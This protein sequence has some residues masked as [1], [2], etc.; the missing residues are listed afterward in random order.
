MPAA[1]APAW[2]SIQSGPDATTAPF[3]G[4]VSCP[5]NCTESPSGSIPESGMVILT[6]SPAR[7]RAVTVLGTGGLF[8]AASRS[9]TAMDTSAVAH[10]PSA[11]T[12]R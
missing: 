10:C 11:P 1:Y 6:V 5:M 8:V 2:K 3:W 9:R 7:T 12:T 4:L